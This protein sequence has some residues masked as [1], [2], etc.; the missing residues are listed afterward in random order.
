M[1][2]TEAEQALKR[3]CLSWRDVCSTILSDT[4]TA[5]IPLQLTAAL[6]KQQH[7]ALQAVQM[8]L[9]D[10]VAELTYFKANSYKIQPLNDGVER[11]A[12]KY[13]SLFERADR[14]FDV[15][16]STKDSPGLEGLVQVPLDTN[17][18]SSALALYRLR[19]L[20]PGADIQMGQAV[21][22]VWEV[23]LQT[24]GNVVVL[25]DSEGAFLVWCQHYNDD[26]RELLAVIADPECPHPGSLTIAGKVGIGQRSCKQTLPTAQ[27]M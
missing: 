8:Q 21:E 9:E 14:L 5:Q 16:T 17:T 18:I 10:A 24:D 12:G 23:C 15:W 4:D 1:V 22:T 27:Q 19:C 7:S 11:V 26:V 13:D 20:F 3:Q 6:L 25:A 2:I